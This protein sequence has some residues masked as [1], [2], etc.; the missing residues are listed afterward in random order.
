MKTALSS[1]RLRLLLSFALVSSFAI[2]VA[3]AASFSFNKVGLGLQLITTQRMPAAVAAGEMARS[4]E[5]IVATTPELLN[6]RDDEEKS[7]IREQLDA[8]LADL[9]RSAARR[10]VLSASCQRIRIAK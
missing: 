9:K 6:A 1:L 10:K 8:E 3:L 2:I 7:R 4:V 5:S